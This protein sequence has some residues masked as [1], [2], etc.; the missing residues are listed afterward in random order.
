MWNTDFILLY[1]L[2]MHTYIR[3]SFLEEE[4]MA[5]EPFSLAKLSLTVRRVAP[6][7]KETPISF[8]D[9]EVIHKKLFYRRN[10]FPYPVLPLSNY[11]LPVNGFVETP[12]L[13][14]LQEITRLPSKTIKLVLECSG[15]K[16]E[17]FKPKVFGEQ[18]EKG[19]M[20]QGYWK[21]VPLKTF[22]EAAGVK[23]G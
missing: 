7:N 23:K 18:W 19:A 17:F 9:S 16:R 4:N 5:N 10:H 22:L 8:I 1:P 6:E 21:G 14:S 15:N 13:F 2:F 20:N 11:W 3:R 12:R